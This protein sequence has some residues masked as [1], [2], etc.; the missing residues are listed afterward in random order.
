M[1]SHQYSLTMNGVQ[2]HMFLQDMFYCF[3]Y[4]GSHNFSG[5]TPMFV[6]SCDCFIYMLF[7]W[8]YD[9]MCAISHILST[10]VHEEWFKKL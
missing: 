5:N 1:L 9:E 6:N 7:D 3:G 4:L 10:R 2:L 8:A